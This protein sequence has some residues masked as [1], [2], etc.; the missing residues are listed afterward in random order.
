MIIVDQVTVDNGIE[1]IEEISKVMAGF[2]G[3]II[4]F[5]FGT[6]GHSS[7]QDTDPDAAEL[8]GSADSPTSDSSSN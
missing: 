8:P 7:S 4:G 1:I 5:Y 2:I 6:S 3:L